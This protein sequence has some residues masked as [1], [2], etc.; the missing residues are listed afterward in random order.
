MQTARPCA[1]LRGWVW[2]PWFAALILLNIPLMAAVDPLD[3]QWMSQEQTERLVF[4]RH[5]VLKPELADKLRAYVDKLPAEQKERWR[6][7]VEHL[8]EHPPYFLAR[9]FNPFLRFEDSSLV[10]ML[11][12][13]ANH[14]DPV[15]RFW[16]LVGLVG[17]G[18]DKEAAAALLRLPAS[19]D[20]SEQDAW[21]LKNLF[22]G[23]G[24][25]PQQ[26]NAD[27]VFRFLTMAFG[28]TDTKL[29]PGSMAP[30]FEIKSL[31][32]QKVKLS[33]FRGKICLLHFWSLDCPPCV[34]EMPQLQKEIRRWKN[35][36]KQLVVIGVNLDDDLKRIKA[37]AAEFG[38]DAVQVCDGRGWGSKP[39]KLYRVNSIPTDV[40]ID[41]NG[42]IRGYQRAVLDRLTASGGR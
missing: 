37:K 15:S 20:L 25:D 41:R 40:V 19:K 34:A 32:G 11:R 29:A 13:L 6:G 42:I 33:D 18:Q 5:I 35:Q 1:G 4:N 9:N 2:A 26:D 36:D 16:A 12:E 38:L 39:A 14:N 7:V 30:D 3:E 21:I 31:V 24:I 10:P 22:H 17:S 27:E 23:V 28:S 8:S